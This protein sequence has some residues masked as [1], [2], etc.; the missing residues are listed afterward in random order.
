MDNSD[1]YSIAVGE[2]GRLVLPARLRQ[3]L[4]LQPG[5]R[6]IATIDDER[7]IRLVAARDLARQ[8]RG[9]Y[10]ELAPERSLVD[11]LIAE[12]REEVR[13]ADEA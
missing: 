7:G 5:D 10:A 8:L 13:R 2:R 4:N 1:H 9:L 6:L 3:R 12:R 11:E